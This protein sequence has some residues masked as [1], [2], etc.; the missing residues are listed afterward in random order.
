MKGELIQVTMR[1]E[2]NEIN[3]VTQDH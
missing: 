2:L 1:N 3:S